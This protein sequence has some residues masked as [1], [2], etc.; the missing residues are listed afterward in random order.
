[1]KKGLAVII[2]TMLS[3]P[4][5]GLNF[6]PLYAGLDI[7]VKKEFPLTSR[8]AFDAGGGFGS[9]FLTG[10]TLLYFDGGLQYRVY[11]SKDA[12]KGPYLAAGGKF[13]FVVY[14]QSAVDNQIS[15]LALGLDP[16]LRFGW[17]FRL[18]PFE[19]DLS[20]GAGFPA[21]YCFAQHEW[22]DTVSSY[23]PLWTGLNVEFSYHFK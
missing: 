14:G 7:G 9:L 13:E 4:L 22:L 21:Y 6:L 20:L 8:Q 15:S 10:D 1:M 5:Y 3:V 2:L 18:D 11:F 12:F 16:Q 19:V 17:K 23:C